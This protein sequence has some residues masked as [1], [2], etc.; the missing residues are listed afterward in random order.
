MLG[1][2]RIVLGTQ[3]VLNK[4]VSF[5]PFILLWYR[6]LSAGWGGGRE[7]DSGNCCQ[8]FRA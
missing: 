6:G 1:V 8:S 2:L 3:H 7:R 4:C 5:F